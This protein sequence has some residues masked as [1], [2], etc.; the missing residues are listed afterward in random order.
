MVKSLDTLLFSKDFEHQADD[1][2][3]ERFK[4]WCGA[5][6]LP[7]QHVDLV[8]AKAYLTERLREVIAAI[9]AK[10]E[11]IQKAESSVSQGCVPANI[12]EVRTRINQIEVDVRAAERKVEDLNKEHGN[13]IETLGHRSKLHP[14]WMR[15]FSFIPRVEALRADLL[16]QTATTL[17]FLPCDDASLD[18]LAKLYNAVDA[19]FVNRK[20]AATIQA[21]TLQT[22]RSV[23]T[24]LEPWIAGY[25]D[26]NAVDAV[27][28]ANRRI[29]VELRSKA[30]D[31]AMRMREAEL[32]LGR[33]CP[34]SFE[35]P[36]AHGLV[37][38]EPAAARGR[39]SISASPLVFPR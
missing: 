8:F 13:A 26:P 21:Q 14:L 22:Q 19:E 18:S 2:F 29:D 6:K 33:A 9:K 36:G 15:W 24:E 10:V 37:R 12:A 38:L 25:V 17:K 7:P 28:A 5:D 32:L 16:R 34:L 39:C 3:L 1:Y 4:E 27:D 31:L 20:N 30:F 23:W 11:F 35:F